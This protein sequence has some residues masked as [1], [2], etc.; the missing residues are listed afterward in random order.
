[1]Y[2]RYF[3]FKENP[4][5]IAPDPRFLYM[6]EM[7]QDALAHLNYGLSPESCIILLTGEVGTG[8]TTICRCF[9]E[10]LDQKTNVAVILNPKL[11][12]LE[13]L[14]AICDEFQ[15]PVKG[16]HSS[17]KSHIDSL[18][19]FLLQAHAQDRCCLLI[20][21][22]AQNLDPDVL[23]MVRLLTNLETDQRKLLKIYLFG[24]SE[25]SAILARPDMAQIDQRITVRCHLKG[26]EPDD[27][28]RYIN[29]R[30]II[31]GGGENRTLFDPG[32]IKKIHRLS[33]GIPRLINTICD[34]SL[35]GAY[36][37]G[38]TTVKA[39]IV[40][41]AGRE[42]SGGGTAKQNSWHVLRIL[43]T[44]SVTACIVVALSAGKI[45]EFHHDAQFVSDNL[46]NQPEEASLLPD[47]LPESDHSPAPREGQQAPQSFS[48][49][50][51]IKQN[52]G[53][54]SAAP[55]QNSRDDFAQSSSRSADI[56]QK[57]GTK[58]TIKSMEISE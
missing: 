28:S 21:D 5:S 10:Q 45:S 53:A 8:K 1:M 50:P 38:K 54:I 20:I 37:E 55:Q 36:S 25:L 40:K 56:A 31:A 41:K 57:E 22:E 18:N 12:A 3:G 34:R 16:E 52:N 14:S 43:I 30:V 44:I 4:F 42:L 17:V 2:N 48:T 39:A 27:M 47:S 11:S 51:E 13:L 35:L 32:A 15:I 24:Q 49:A 6:S 29:H 19:R 33:G 9:L 46:N 58:I 26:L 23:E 7:H